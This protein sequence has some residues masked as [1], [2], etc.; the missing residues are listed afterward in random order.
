VIHLIGSFLEYL[1]PFI[2]ALGI[3]IFAHE[4]GHF[5]VAKRSGIRVEVFS[6]GYA[7]KMLGI[8]L[9]ETEYRISWIPFGGYVKMAGQ[10]DVG[11]PEI[12]GEPWEYPSKPVPVRMAVIAAG[13]VMNFLLAF[14]LFFLLLFVEG[15]EK[16][17]PV[18]GVV[19]EGSLAHR[20]G[21]RAGDRILSVG[22]APVDS[23]DAIAE[24]F[25]F[26]EGTLLDFEVEREGAR[27]HLGAEAN[28]ENIDF[29]LYPYVPPVVA[30]VLPNSPAERAGMEQGDA[31]T[32]IDGEAVHGWE[33]MRRQVSTHPGDTLLVSWIRGGV[34]HQAHI[35]P[36]AR[37]TYNEQNEK[38]EYGVIGV[39]RQA[40][41]ERLGLLASLKFGALQT[42]AVTGEILGFLRKLLVGRASPRLLG[43]PLMIAELAGESA[44]VG[45]RNLFFFIAFLS[46][47]LALV[48]ILPIP[49]LDG[50]HLLFLT[51]EGIV[52]RPLSLKQRAIVQQI[53]LGFLLFT[54][55]YVVIN[56][57]T[58]YFGR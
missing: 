49:A 42:Y 56:D 12:K 37:K 28:A 14:L 5:L 29:G 15:V 55:V 27:L 30:S 9:G 32:S 19:E 40:Q 53:G 18:V 13:P 44:R 50:G 47:N 54:M 41:Y 52:R 4:L 17:P 31:V 43:G 10:S 33:D 39:T 48:N 26:H 36:T 51:V 23:W 57:I 11:K 46:V 38:I 25:F 21:F 24:S 6:L 2:F 20:A 3:L 45:L 7:P 1:I 34:E 35:V 58:R 16:F 8:R 22:G